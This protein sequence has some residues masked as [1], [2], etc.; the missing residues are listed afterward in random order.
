VKILYKKIHVY[1]QG[2]LILDYP[3]KPV[4]IDIIKLEVKEG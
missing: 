1:N 3:Q 2:L 4:I